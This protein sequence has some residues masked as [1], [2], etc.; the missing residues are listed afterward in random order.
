L[1]TV[2][3]RPL[4]EII[5]ECLANGHWHGDLQH[6]RKDGTVVWDTSYWAV[7]NDENET[8]QSMIEVNTDVTGRRRAEQVMQRTNEAL[9]RFAFTVSHDLKEPLRTIISYLQLLERRYKHGL[10]QDASDFI[11]ISV[12][13]AGRMQTLID[14]LL[15]YARSGREE[16]RHGPVDA[17]AALDA[18]IANL[19]ASIEETQP[20][21]LIEPLPPARISAEPFALV[22]Q[23]LLSNA[24]KYR[25][26]DV[27]LRIRISGFVQRGFATYSVEDNGRGFEQGQADRIFRIFRRLHM[28]V[29]GSG[30]GLALCRRIVENYGGTISAKSEPE[31]GAKFDFTLPA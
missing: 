29:P 1:K 8:P 2:F 7:H 23:N 3:P 14:G 21:I 20:Q 15:L 27:P 6:A 28:D 18:A 11:Q 17:R 22:F 4:E 26:P 25:R 10:D 13:A 9:E 30:I 16:T 5:A 12:D 31:R 19:R 24:I